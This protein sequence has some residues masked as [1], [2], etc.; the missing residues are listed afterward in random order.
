MSLSPIISR[1]IVATRLLF[2]M[3]QRNKHTI[4]DLK[5]S[6]NSAMEAL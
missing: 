5:W 4:G 6:A 2:N 1:D 3:I